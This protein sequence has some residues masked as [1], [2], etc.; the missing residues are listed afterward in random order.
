MAL[1]IMLPIMHVIY[2]AKVINTLRVY[3]PDIKYAVMWT[4]LATEWVSKNI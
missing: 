2:V 1:Y 4:K 3:V